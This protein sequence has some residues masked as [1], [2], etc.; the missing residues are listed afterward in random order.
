MMRWTL[1]ALYA[2]A[3]VML[4]LMVVDDFFMGPGKPKQ[5]FIRLALC[6][7]WPVVALSNRGRD[8]LFKQW[9]GL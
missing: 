6:F 2:T 3:T 9:R 7:L 8:L 1:F 4:V 5:L